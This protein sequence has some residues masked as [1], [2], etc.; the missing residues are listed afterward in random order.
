MATDARF[1]SWAILELMGHRRLA[2]YLTEIELGGGRF[3]RLDMPL[4]DGTTMSQIYSPSA[5]YCITP[6][7]EEVAKVVAAQNEPQ[8]LHYFEMRRLQAPT[9]DTEEAETDPD[10]V[11]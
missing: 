1:E 6:T 10:Q 4:K 5:V 9:E 7:V 2:G 8:P 3:L 11:F